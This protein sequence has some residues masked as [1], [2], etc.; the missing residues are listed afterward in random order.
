MPPPPVKDIDRGWKAIM[1]E[2]KKFK[3][4]DFVVDVGL[5]GKEA[6]QVHAEEGFGGKAFI[7]TQEPLTNAKLASFHEFGTVAGGSARS[8]GSVLH[9]PERSFI[10]STIDEKQNQITR[11]FERVAGAVLGLHMTWERGFGIIGVQ[12]TNWIK[13]KIRKGIPPPLMPATIAARKRQFG[14]ASS[15]PLI[16]SGQLLGAITHEVRRRSEGEK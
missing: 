16:A 11:L 7:G 14:K 13:A 9:V 3:D 8:G 12:V 2:I 5:V 10:R 15:K 1:R 6:G 4:Y